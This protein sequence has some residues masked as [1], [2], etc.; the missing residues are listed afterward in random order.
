M[1]NPLTKGAV[2]LVSFLVMLLAL[3]TSAGFAQEKM[4]WEEYEATLLSWQQREMD[5]KAA[6][7]E[8]VANIERIQAEI[9][10]MDQRI[11]HN[12]Q[13]M[14]SL[15]GIKQADV[16]QLDKKMAAI[17]DHIDRMKMMSSQDLEFKRDEI[18]GIELEI[19]QLN[20][21]PASGLPAMQRKMAGLRKA[22]MELRG[23]LP[24]LPRTY[25]VVKGEC[26][27]V[28][29]GY[30]QIYDDPLK[31]PRIYRAN[32]DKIKDPNLIYPGW[33]LNIPRGFPSTHTVIEGEYLSKIAS[34]WEIYN[35]AR[36]WPRIYRANQDQIKDPDMIF[37][38]QMLSIP[39]D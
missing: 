18:D 5:A 27:Y 22:L 26:L 13:E 31:W 23:K 6:I 34:Y 9:A 7:A 14:Y 36:Q 16:D 8:E 28:I 10:T 11:A 12:T 35:D 15:L 4:S 17:M 25:T 2:L 37:P 38:G 1:K 32:K 33:V 21:L 39:R 29:S 20:K 3:S 24:K 19:D 30:S